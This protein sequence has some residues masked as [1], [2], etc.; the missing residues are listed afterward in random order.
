[1]LRLFSFRRTEMVRGNIDKIFQSSLDTNNII[2]EGIQIHKCSIENITL[3]WE[4]FDLNDALN[5]LRYI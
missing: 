5:V 3:A 4:N 1:M 2:L